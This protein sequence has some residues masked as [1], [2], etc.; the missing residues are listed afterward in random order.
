MENN[1]WSELVVGEYISG[2][3]VYTIGSKERAPHKTRE[4]K[5]E[6]VPLEAICGD[7]TKLYKD[8]V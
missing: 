4:L 5:F 8:S 3:R 7:R 6:L 1:S 2:R